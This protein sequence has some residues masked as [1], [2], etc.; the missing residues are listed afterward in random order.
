MKTL[1]YALFCFY[2]VL[3]TLHAQRV[4]IGTSTP[5][6]KL[7]VT[8]T[9]EGLL[10]PRV[11]LTARNVMGPVTA[12]TTSEM[13][14]NTATAGTTPNNVVPGYYY[15]NGTQ[16]VRLI[17]DAEMDEDW[18]RA[19]DDQLPMSMNDNIYTMGQVGI[20]TNT[21]G[22]G[23]LTIMSNGVDLMQFQD[24]GGE[25]EWH[26]RTQGAGNANLGFTETGVADHRLVL[27]A[28]GN[29]GIGTD[30]PDYR[31]AV[32]GDLGL[33]NVTPGGWRNIFFSRN[34]NA[35]NDG[36]YIRGEWEDME[37]H[38]NRGSGDFG[39]MYRFYTSGTQRFIIDGVGDV[40]IGTMNN[41]VAPLHI[42]EGTGTA[43][44]ASDGTIVLEHGNSGG[45]SSIIF[46]S[47]VNNNSDYAYINFA[48]D[49]S[50]NGSSNEN[51]LLTI[52]I[53]NDGPGAY[54][55]DIAL[56]PDGY[57]GVGTTTPSN[58]LDVNGYIEVGTDVNGGADE[59]GALR[60][61]TTKKCM[62]FYDG[63]SWK[64]I[65]EPDIQTFL[66]RDGVNSTWDGS[67]SNITNWNTGGYGFQYSF[68]VNNCRAGR[69]IL[70]L[71]EV[72]LGTGDR[73]ANNGYLSMQ[74]LSGHG[75]WQEKEI[76]LVGSDENYTTFFWGTPNAS[77]NLGFV[78]E[79][80]S[81]ETHVKITTIQF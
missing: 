30:D 34:L 39:G 17:T 73:R 62:E 72:V 45:S 15:W 14:Y 44:S 5:Q 65:G 12:A 63:T 52:G 58:K 80:N 32:N 60:Y 48:D 11:A 22:S 6:A 25:N 2:G 40:G 67:G 51:A 50:G 41:P 18:M 31:L 49:G 35:A 79:N 29:I 81:H 59:E 13:V 78:F 23:R 70:F 69:K 57:V 26:L 74:K 77:G 1:F 71:V 76:P 53:E 66:L 19:I 27:K 21:M 47:N 68:T 33:G 36:P 16:W 42:L 56:M 61:N 38:A 24:S 20:G 3:G 75:I 4:G 46:K 10:M 55:D 37:F 9:D 28:G 8:A 64:C 7:D 43:A 54:Q